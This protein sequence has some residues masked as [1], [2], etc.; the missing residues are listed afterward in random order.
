MP[1][2]EGLA[3]LSGS[4]STW[5]TCRWAGP[6]E[7]GAWRAVD[8]GG[9]GAKS[10]SR[11]QRTFVQ[12]GGWRKDLGARKKIGLMRAECSKKAINESELG[13]RM[14]EYKF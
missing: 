4:R 14:G 8:R 7:M 1:R 6:S 2:G 9:T 13:D 5:R 12:L 10:R 3:G 11:F